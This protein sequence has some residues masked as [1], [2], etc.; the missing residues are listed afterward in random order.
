MKKFLFRFILFVL[1]LCG[2]N[3]TLNIFTN[4]EFNSTYFHKEQYLFSKIDNYSILFF[5]T[6]R[7]KRN[8]V[9]LIFDNESVGCT[10]SFNSLI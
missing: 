9:P 1:I 10:S 2:I 7:T 3:F 6:S 5:G 4:N 8:I